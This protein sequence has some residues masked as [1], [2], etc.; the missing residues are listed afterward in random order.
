MTN[1]ARCLPL[2][3]TQG[4][5]IIARALTKR[6]PHP[7]EEPGGA[8]KRAGD[9]SSFGGV[10]PVTLSVLCLPRLAPAPYPPWLPLRPLS[11]VVQSSCSQVFPRLFTL[12]PEPRIAFLVLKPFTVTAPI[13]DPRSQPYSPPCGIGLKFGGYHARCSRRCKERPVTLLSLTVK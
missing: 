7:P 10:R 4:A 1:G 11:M 13:Y 8:P 9:E 3:H 12:G 2:A 6:C 5:P